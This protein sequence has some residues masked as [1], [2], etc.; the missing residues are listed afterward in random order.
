MQKT[1]Q[2][3]QSG[4]SIDPDRGATENTTFCFLLHK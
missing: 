1:G 3:N 2:Q 4:H